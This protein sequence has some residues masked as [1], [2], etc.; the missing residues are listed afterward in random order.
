VLLKGQS[1]ASS[2][3]EMSLRRRIK[4]LSGT[5][6]ASC[7]NGNFGS[8]PNSKKEPNKCIRYTWT[9]LQAGRFG[10]RNSA[11]SRDIFLCFRISRPALEPTQPPTKWVKGS[12]PGL[13]LSEHDVKHSPPYFTEVKKERNR[14]SV[15]PC[16]PSWR[17]HFIKGFPTRSLFFPVHVTCP[18]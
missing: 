13:R 10:V 2:A 6:P 14:N 3:N 18:H 9:A 11:V 1:V 5:H 8:Y 17:D 12:L 16:K 7:L 15:P 4:T